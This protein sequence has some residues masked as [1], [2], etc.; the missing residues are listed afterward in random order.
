MTAT[1]STKKA[2]I[3]RIE[4]LL[5]FNHIFSGSLFGMAIAMAIKDK[6]PEEE[7]LKF[8]FD[9]V[10]DNEPLMCATMGSLLVAN[11]KNLYL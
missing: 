1:P 4:Y 6:T 8:L 10:T 5:K 3:S 2:I 7:I 9:N 11:I